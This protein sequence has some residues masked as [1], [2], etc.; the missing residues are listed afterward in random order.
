VEN[1]HKKRKIPIKIGN[2]PFITQHVTF[3]NRAGFFVIPIKSGKFPLK[4]ENS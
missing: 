1:S 3:D 2:I 4:A